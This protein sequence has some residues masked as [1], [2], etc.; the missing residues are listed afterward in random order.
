MHG[1]TGE[2][3]LVRFQR[4]EARALKPI[5]GIPSFRATRELI[6][7]V[8]TDCAVEVDGNAYSV[9]WRLIGERVL[10]TV[11]DTTIRIHHGA[12]QVAVHPVCAGRRQRAVDPRHFDGIVGAGRPRPAETLMP[13]A[14]APAPALLRPLG[15]YEALLGGGF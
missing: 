15:E 11:T 12:R 5:A 2:A 10:V 4:D 9:P 7:R 3:P 13:M 14:A 1:T 8:Q 6:R